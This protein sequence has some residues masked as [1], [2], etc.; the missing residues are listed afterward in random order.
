MTT[1]SIHQLD[2]LLGQSAAAADAQAGAVFDRQA[3]PGE[4]ALVLFGSGALGRMVLDRLRKVGIEPVAFADNNPAAWG[5]TRDGVKVLSPAA[6][7]QQFGPRAVFVNTIYTAAPIRKQLTDM[8]VRWASSSALFLRHP[9]EML[10]FLCIDLPSRLLA[11]NAAVRAGFSVWADEASRREYLG[12]VR[13]RLSLDENLPPHLS[14]ESTYFPPE[15]FELG[16][17]TLVDCGAFDGDTI[18]SLLPRINNDP[19]A[20]IGIEPD[21]QN[22]QKLLKYFASLGPELQKRTRAH[23]VA[24]GDKREK[25]SFAADGTVGSSI[26]GAG[27]TTVDCVPLDEL[28]ADTAPTFIKMDIEGA[29]PQT[30][31]GAAGILRRHSP[32]LAICLYHLQDHLW[33][34]PNFIK[35]INP[36]YKMFLRRHSD[37][38]WEQVCYA[39]PPHRVRRGLLDTHS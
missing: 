11:Q 29:E 22:C 36:D 3:G 27:S 31:R 34:I 38:C 17:E 21:P 15:L 28:L 16:R 37:D 19:A 30:L 9:R 25:L 4:Q 6:A 26:A 35:S 18:R 33:T 14:A 8:E 7:A 13:F 32:I 5:Q 1:T 23:Q 12:Q 2:E 10:P 39:V 20:L 24:T